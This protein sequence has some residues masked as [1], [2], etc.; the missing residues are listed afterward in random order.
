MIS[1]WSSC[2]DAPVVVSAAL[3]PRF[4][5]VLKPW[6][7]RRNE[8][9]R[10]TVRLDSSRFPAS[11]KMSAWI[12]IVFI[13]KG[14]RGNHK[15]PNRRA[16]LLYLSSETLSMSLQLSPALTSTFNGAASWRAFSIDSLI[17]ETTR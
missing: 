6:L 15:N 10:F 3:F 16:R 7:N 9:P 13:S 1:V 4:S 12:V 11:P 8:N 17:S 14:K 5:K 2:L